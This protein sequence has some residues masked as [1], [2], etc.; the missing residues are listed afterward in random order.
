MKA[1]GGMVVGA[2]RGPGIMAVHTRL[3]RK[4]PNSKFKHIYRTTKIF[5][6]Q[7]DKIHNICHPIK[8]YKA[9]QEAGKNDP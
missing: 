5:S 3:T 1:L 9:Y 2:H 7:Q 4:P 6:T 8:Y